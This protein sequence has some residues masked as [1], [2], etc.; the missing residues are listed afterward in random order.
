MRFADEIVPVKELETYLPTDVQ[1]S[2]K[3]LGMAKTLIDTLITKFD[4]SNYENEYHKQVIQMI[5]DK[6][7]NEDIA[8]IIR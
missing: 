8:L 6:A 2:D 5:E 4:P 1:L 7:G 3:E